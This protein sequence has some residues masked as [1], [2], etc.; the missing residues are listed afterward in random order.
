[1]T[2]APVP[3]LAKVVAVVTEQFKEEGHPLSPPEKRLALALFHSLLDTPTLPRDKRGPRARYGIAVERVMDIINKYREVKRLKAEGADPFFAT[4]EL[5]GMLV[6]AKIALG[7]LPAIQAGKKVASGGKKSAQEQHGD[8]AEEYAG[9]CE[10]F[11][12]YYSRGMLKGQAE[13]AAA[14]KH[15]VRPRT[16]RKA[17]QTRALSSGR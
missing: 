9:M 14:S 3:A 1:M 11:D 5:G 7:L 10:S 13:Q 8:I 4:L 12:R 2:D 15:G 16:I 17:R 6:F